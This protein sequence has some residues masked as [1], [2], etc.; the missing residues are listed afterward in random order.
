MALSSI[1]LVIHESSV[2]RGQHGWIV[3]CTHWLQSIDLLFA[4]G[5]SSQGALQL[6]RRHDKYMM[7]VVHGI[8]DRH[9]LRLGKA[10][11]R[12]LGLVD[13]HAHLTA[14]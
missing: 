1:G 10:P 7:Y 8:Y 11:E 2:D 13:M 4:V 6:A 14:E 3:R 5:K 12:C 9:I